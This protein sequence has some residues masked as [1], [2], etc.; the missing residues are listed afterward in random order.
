[1]LGCENAV[2]FYRTSAVEYL[3]DYAEFEA[4]FVEMFS[5]Y[6]REI[7]PDFAPSLGL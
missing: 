2:K 6:C 1:M 7:Y 5:E 3:L 4:D